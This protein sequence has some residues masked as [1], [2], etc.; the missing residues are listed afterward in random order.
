MLEKTVTAMASEDKTESGEHCIYCGESTL[1]RK[2]ILN[3]KANKELPCCSKACLSEAR[4]FVRWDTQSRIKFYLLE[5]V[6]II[7][8]LVFLGFEWITRWRYLPFIG[9][10]I[11]LYIF[12][13]PFVHYSSYQRFGIH[14]TLKII[15]GIAVGILAAGIGFMVLG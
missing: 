3:P 5:L 14:R 6:F 4:E 11:I 1:N 15:R 10:G 7:I 12:P 8:N 13:L 9:M 2:Y